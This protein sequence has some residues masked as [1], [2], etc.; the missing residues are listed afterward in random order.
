MIFK[1]VNIALKSRSQ[2]IQHPHF[3]GAMLQQVGYDMRP[4]KSRA[5]RYQKLL[6]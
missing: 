2:V 6:T 1:Q 5:S 3:P 4:N